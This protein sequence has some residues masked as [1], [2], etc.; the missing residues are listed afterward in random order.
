M[1]LDY[2]PKRVS[3][4]VKKYRGTP[5]KAVRSAAPVN[6]NVIKTRNVLCCSNNKCK[7]K[8]SGKMW[9]ILC[10]FMIQFNYFT[11]Y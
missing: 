3:K 6:T 4:N 5:Y 11:T 9:F 2:V 7:G 10:L 8:E 1:E